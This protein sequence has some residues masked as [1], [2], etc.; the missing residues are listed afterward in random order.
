MQA[1]TI[2]VEYTPGSYELTESC[3]NV[4]PGLLGSIRKEGFTVRDRGTGWAE[5]SKRSCLTLVVKLV[6]DESDP[7]EIWVDFFFKRNLG[8]LTKKRRDSIAQ[9]MPKRV[10]LIRKK[11]KRGTIFYRV[12][13]RDMQSWL[14]RAKALL[15]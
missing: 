8:R 11:S 10:K 9:A 14:R 3:H 12:A 2:G 7:I 4:C 6:D 15:N 13:D 1:Q 5:V